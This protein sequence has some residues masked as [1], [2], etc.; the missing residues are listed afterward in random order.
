MKKDLLSVQDLGSQEIFELINLAE[1]MKANPDKYQDALKGKSIGLIF[2]KPSTRT[3]VSFEI[4]MFQMGGHS[5]Y[6]GSSEIGMGGRESVKDVACVLSRYLNG[7]V[8]RT[9]K[10]EIAEELAKY[11]SIPVSYTHLTLPT[12]RIV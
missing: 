8:A 2:Q 10:H 6:L 5:I 3:R 12:K 1:D 4:G 11:S 7:I 9:Y